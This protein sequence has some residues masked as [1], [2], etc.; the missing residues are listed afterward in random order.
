MALLIHDPR[1]VEKPRKRAQI[2]VSY[3][4]RGC[5]DA[6]AGKP[7]K[8]PS[9]GGGFDKR[10]TGYANGYDYAQATYGVALPSQAAL[11]SPRVSMP[12]GLTPGEKQAFMLGVAACSNAG[13][14]ASGE[15]KL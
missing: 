2:T 1:D 4:Q 12:P 7:Y 5:N 11:D 6:K 14:I 10:N 8:P 3:W 15:V 13:V 9:K